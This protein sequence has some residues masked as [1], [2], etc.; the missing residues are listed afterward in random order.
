MCDMFHTCWH[1]PFLFGGSWRGGDGWIAM[2]GFA[3]PGLELQS[4][5]CVGAGSQ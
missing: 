2:A 5:G 1:F 4:W 3:G